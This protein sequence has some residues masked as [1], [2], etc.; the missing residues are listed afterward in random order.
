MCWDL[1][2]PTLRVRNNFSA[3]DVSNKIQGTLIVPCFTVLRNK[4][5]HTL[6]LFFLCTYDKQWPTFFP[7]LFSLLH[8]TAQGTEKGFNRHIS[9]LFFHIVLEISGEV[10]DQII[11]SARSFTAE[12]HARDG[13]VRDGV[14]ERDAGRI[15]EA[16]L[17]IVAEAAERMTELRKNPEQPSDS[18]ELDH[19]IEVVD[20]GVR[21]FGSYVGA[22]HCALFGGCATVLTFHLGWIDITLTVTPTTVPLL[23]SLLDDPSLP[24]RLATSVAL[25]RIISKGL[26]EP[27]DK[28][29]L[30]KVLSLGQVLE[31]LES[32][33]RAQQR[34]RG[35][36]TD[37]GE[38]SYRE[39][40]GKLLN[41][42]GHELAKLVDVSA[43]TVL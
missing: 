18:K 29:Q 19:A 7:D 12:R 16:V 26:K 2:K 33:T 20:W 1:L 3:I 17:T 40:L 32:K 28:L 37:E 10:A 23:F 27:G 14:R 5:S 34:E 11:K 35:E 42:L 31:A 9:L 22:F 38:E 4:F 25:L 30:L 13:K 6:T 36:D 43:H 8:P 39:A 41:V 24:I 21:T 15:N